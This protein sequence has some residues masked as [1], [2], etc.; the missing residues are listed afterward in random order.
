VVKGRSIGRVVYATPRH[1]SFV[2]IFDAEYHGSTNAAPH[3]EE[4]IVKCWGLM[5]AAW[6][7]EENQYRRRSVFFASAGRGRAPAAQRHEAR[8]HPRQR[9]P[10]ARVVNTICV[11]RPEQTTRRVAVR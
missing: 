6:H 10:D 5:V 3:A 4:K 1:F 9:Q 7:T 8:K 2:A 11:K